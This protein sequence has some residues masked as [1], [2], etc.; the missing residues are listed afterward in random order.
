MMSDE[1]STSLDQ[2]TAS[3]TTIWVISD[4]KPGHL[5]QSLGLSEALQRQLSDCQIMIIPALSKGSALAALLKK[6]WPQ[7]DTDNDTPSLI[8]GAGHRTHLSLLA[9]GRA[10][11][12]ATVV[13]MKPSLPLS[14]F[15]CCLIPQ[16]DQPA[17]RNNVI[18]TRGALNRMQP[19]EADQKQGMM[20]I[21]GPSKHFG[22][23]NGK[24]VAQVMN[25]CRQSSAN[26]HWTLTT[27]RRTPSD[28]LP[29]LATQSLDNLTLVPVE[30]TGPG[31]LA[32]KLPQASQCWV[33]SD[34]VSMVYEAL[35]AGCA[36]GLLE[37]P[38]LSEN[39][40]AQGVQQLADENVLTP[41][42]QWLPGE[43]LTPP[44]SPFNEADRCAF[45][46]RQQLS[47]L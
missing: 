26:T 17:H 2:A 21:G 38:Q 29:L 1:F 30:E 19:G 18:S 3:V 44:H 45:A 23:D 16:H 24:M 11:N 12:A 37:V 25:I 40:I 7:A 36:T 33:S 39:R 43:Q 22:W 14:W 31:W 47:V 15:D 42:T 28:F 46:L 35:S 10:F 32:E 13:L 34:S 27:S 20:L 8:I 41:Y 5:N 9:A 4:G 6:R